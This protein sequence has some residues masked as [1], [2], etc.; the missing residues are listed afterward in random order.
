[1]VQAQE[2]FS[3]SN[4]LTRPEK[5]LI[6]GFMAGSRE[7]PRPD[8]G[9]LI[10]IKLNESE[11]FFTSSTGQQHRVLSEVFFQMDYNTGEYKKIKRMKPIA[12]TGVV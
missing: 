1:M 12:N 8:Q 3:N 7:N 9:N 4:Q 6:L 11:E 5:A 2:M 10:T